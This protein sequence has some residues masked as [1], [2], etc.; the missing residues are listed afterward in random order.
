MKDKN[1]CYRRDFRC[2]MKVY[3]LTSNF[4]IG[5]VSSHT[6]WCITHQD[7]WNFIYGYDTV[8]DCSILIIIVKLK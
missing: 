8:V 5:L 1:Y 2:V 7:N 6:I 3:A 4:K